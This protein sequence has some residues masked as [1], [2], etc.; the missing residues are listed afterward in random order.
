MATY[1]FHFPASSDAMLTIALP[2]E[3]RGE[4]LKIVV[5]KEPE[6]SK[7]S[8]MREFVEKYSGILADCGIEGVEA[9]KAERINDRIAR[10]Q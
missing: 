10:H 9:M 7:C 1:Q 6:P 4:P 2:E 8:T 3:L 5:A